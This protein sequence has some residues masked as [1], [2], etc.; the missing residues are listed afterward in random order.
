MAKKALGR[1]L[2]ALIPKRLIEE[3]KGSAQQVPVSRIKPR[4]KDP[5]IRVPAA[6][7]GTGKVKHGSKLSSIL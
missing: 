5:H 2:E 7:S 3:K 6:F 1:G 4:K